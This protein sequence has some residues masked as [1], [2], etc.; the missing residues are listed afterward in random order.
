MVI[1]R[2]R[3]VKKTLI[4]YTEDDIKIHLRVSHGICTRDFPFSEE[5]FQTSTRFAY[6]R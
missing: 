3:R 4:F 1:T 5:K 6:E 2:E